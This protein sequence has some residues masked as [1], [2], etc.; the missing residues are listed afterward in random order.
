MCRATIDHP[1]RDSS[2][3]ST[4]KSRSRSVETKGTIATYPA[5][6]SIVLMGKST[7]DSFNCSYQKIRLDRRHERSLSDPTTIYCRRPS[8]HFVEVRLLQSM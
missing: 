2:T 4:Q 8:P 1:H 5:K 3:V 7:C 6:Y